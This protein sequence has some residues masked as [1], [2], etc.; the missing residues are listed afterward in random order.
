MESRG[1]IP[2]W[3]RGDKKLRENYRGVTL[4]SMGYKVYANILNKKL[5]KELDEKEGWSRTQAGFRKGRETIENVK[6]L[7]HGGKENKGKKE[8]MGLF[9]RS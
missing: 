2:I 7:K 1:T 3:K 9:Y 6:I 5:V 8:G 4:T